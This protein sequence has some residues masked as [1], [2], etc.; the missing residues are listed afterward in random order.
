M[1]AETHASVVLTVGQPAPAFAL[2]AGDG[3][4]VRLADLRGQ[5]VVLYFYPKDDT[6]GCTKEACGFRDAR[7][8]FTKATAVILGVSCDDPASHRRFAEKFRLPFPLLSDRDG[9]VCRAYGVYTRKSMFGHAYW[10]IERTTVVIDEHGR[11]AH[12][13]PKVH[14]D[15]HPEAVLQALTPSTAARSR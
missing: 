11:I 2:P 9:A 14:V 6:P 7:S 4:I 1:P 12:L 15:G 13:F 10:G 8:R 3:R 5:R